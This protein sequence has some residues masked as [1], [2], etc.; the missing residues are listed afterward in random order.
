MSLANV[1][2]AA[3]PR[4]RCREIVEADFEGL[5][6]LLVSGFGNTPHHW[7]QILKR[8]AEHPTPR[9]FPKYG[10][11]LDCEERPVGVILL[12]FSSIR[13][14]RKTEIRCNVC[15]WHVKPAFK[16]YAALLASRALR[17]KD[18]TYVNVAPAPHTLPILKAQ[19]YERYCS[20]WF[21]TVPSLFARSHGAR[22]SAV[23]SN[24]RPD[25]HLHSAEIELLLAHAGYGCLSLICQSG[26]VRHPF[27][28]MRRKIGVISFAYLVYCRNIE[29]Y[30]RFAGPLGRYLARRGVSLIALDS[31][32]R[33]RGLLGFYFDGYP[34]YFKGPDQ[35][36]LGD[37]SY[38]ELAMFR[39]AGDKVS[40]DRRP[41]LLSSHITGGT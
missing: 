35:P 17:C 37:L 40:R 9:G 5:V 20:G 2:T 6:G 38:S 18:V 27:V 31:N 30:V 15:G 19:R 36:R 4:V 29:D 24:I 22:V 39:F 13:V 14:D 11:L 10:Y 32:G 28:F 34:K 7:I 23:A 16:G 1:M 21:V 3:P 25:E 8:L 26:N 41:G 12:V 33:I